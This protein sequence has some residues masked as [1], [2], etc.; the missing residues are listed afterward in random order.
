MERPGLQP[1]PLVELVDTTS[2]KL[3]DD[4]VAG[5]KQVVLGDSFQGKIL[6][7]SKGVMLTKVFS[8]K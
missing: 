1:I 2:Q 6:N 7:F 5:V 3:V 4:L 8:C